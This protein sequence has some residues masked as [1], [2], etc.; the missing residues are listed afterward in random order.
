MSIYQKDFTEEL[1]EARKIQMGMLPQSLP[2]ISGF[3]T[4]ACCIP[5]T[6][7][8]GDFYDFITLGDD[9]LGIVVGDAVGHGFPAALLMTMTLTDFRALAPRYMFPAEVL[10]SVNNRLIQSMRTK[11]LVTSIY[12]VLD[13]T[14]KRLMCAMAGMQPWLIKATSHECLP[15]EPYGERFPLGASQKIQYQSCDIQM[16]VGDNLVFYTDGIT[17]ATNE[18]D[19]FYDEERLE[20]VLV[21]N[22][23]ADAQELLNAVMADVRQ[24]TGDR[25][26]EDDITLVVLKA[27][28][29]IAVSPFTPS[30]R[31]ITGERRSVT[32]LFAVGDDELPAE[33]VRQVNALVQEHGGIMDAMSN[34][35]LVALFGV[36]T[37][38]EDD[39]ERAVTAAYAIH[40]FRIGIDTG[41]AIIRSDTDIDYHEMGETMRHALLMANSAESG[42]I[43][44]SE[45]THQLTRGAF[46]FG[47]MAQIQPSD[48][49]S[50]TAYP[51]LSSAEQ[52]HHARGIQGLYSPMI[53]RE[54][55]ME[56]LTAC[57]DDLLNGRGQIVSIAGEAGIGKT[58]LVSELRQ[59]ARDR[60]QW[61][62]GRCISYGQAMNYGP[63]RGII[64]SYLDILPTDT[65]DEMKAKLQSKV[66]ALLS[67]SSRWI[68]IHVGSLFFPQYESELRTA[69]GDD[70]AKQYT[71]PIMRNLFHRMSEKKPLVLVFEDLH[72]ADPTSLALLEFL[73]ESVDE[74]PILY[75][76]LYRPYRDSEVWRLRQRADRDFSYCYT[77]IDLSPLS[78]DHT[79]AILSELLRIPDIPG[80]IRSLVQDKASG[81]P[82]YVEEIIRSFIDGEVVIRDAEYWRA[83]AETTEI[84]PSDTL[85]GVI[86]SRVDR[87]DAEA[88][89]TLQ[90]ASV[91]GVSFPVSLLDQVAE[92][93]SLS[94][95]LRKLEGAEMLT[96]RRS[97]D[98]WEYHF[99]HPLIHDVVYHS[100]LPEDR[101]ALHGKTGKAIETIHTE[102]LDDYTDLLAHHYGYSDNVEKA[103]EYLILAGDNA[104]KQA[105]YWEALDYYG[106]AMQKAERLSDEHQ[107]KLKIVDLVTRRSWARHFLGMLKPDI[108]EHEKYLE[109]VEELG[110]K[111]ISLSFYRYLLSHCLWITEEFE[112][113]KR[114]RKKRASLGG[115]DIALD[116]RI[117]GK[118][119]ERLRIFELLAKGQYE[120]AIA[121]SQQTVEAAKKEMWEPHISY[122]RTLRHA[123]AC[124]IIPGFCLSLGIIA[125]AYA[126]M[127]RWNESLV[128]RQT[129][130]DAAIEYSASTYIIGGRSWLGFIYLAMG[131]W[132]KA[133]AEY[134]AILDA[135]P[136]VFIMT[137][138]AA[139]L[140]DAYCKD[141]Q[142]DKGIALLERW[143]TYVKRVGRGAYIECDY[144]VLLAEGYLAQGDIDKARANAEEALQIAQKHG[145][146]L[147]EAKAYRILGEIIAPRDFPSAEEHFL[148]SLNIMQRIKARNEEGKTE[149]SWGR[150]CKQCDSMP[151]AKEHLTRAA[152]IFEELDTTR[153]LEWTQEAIAE[154]TD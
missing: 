150:T 133:I 51:V 56:Q 111:E 13:T 145:Y 42:Q 139:P 59:Y 83:T 108:E 147:H 64:A 30:A 106:I 154:I 124:G 99:R 75:I 69:S 122:T 90:V 141:G 24:F 135:S 41:T 53:G 81:N 7:V 72:W 104:R 86:L 89:E 115:D 149:L 112:K 119:Y 105:S 84:V 5:A 93:E 132:N 62:E 144:C 50:I 15:I 77:E 39:A 14:S 6:A 65:D 73:M 92:S 102:K 3:Q 140:G 128:A 130:I 82:L 136:S 67:T 29:S 120:E 127:G 101:A 66:S 33:V 68:P 25:P 12:A 1:N 79:D 47:A 97:G 121:V 152:A 123:V 74:A 146:A 58:R 55:E 87:L 134:E 57:I 11:K 116:E 54:R 96:R 19:E 114:Y 95:S 61:L 71:Y 35:T 36:P 34:D 153:Y 117:F 88:K 32:M 143:K 10:N 148:R 76:W 45:R 126:A 21:S 52:P 103:L 37:L 28:E 118:G 137:M 38:H 110:D 129:G 125:G 49:E 60:V 70:Y 17:E 63:F 151:E 18:A 16:D 94:G 113:F 85:Q 131:E 100:L 23:S 2:V 22:S 40:G 142:I 107:R 43:L 78:N 27:T 80:P 4:A 8:G 46:Q 20:R 31:L 44:V 138:V 91:I 48:D 98:E 26:Q 9:K 109:L